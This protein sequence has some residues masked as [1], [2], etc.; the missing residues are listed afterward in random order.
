LTFLQTAEAAG[1][2]RRKVD[3]YVPLARIPADESIAFGIVK[4]LHCSFFHC[5]LPFQIEL[6]STISGRKGDAE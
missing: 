2:D 6:L 3:E 1:L 5:V 4:P